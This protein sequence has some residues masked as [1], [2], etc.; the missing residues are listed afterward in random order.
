MFLLNAIDKLTLLESLDLGYIVEEQA[1]SK[2]HQM[3]Q[4][5]LNRK[6][7]NF[8]LRVLAHLAMKSQATCPL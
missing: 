8:A 5:G 2:Y 6:S 7:E 3:I 1:R 4:Q